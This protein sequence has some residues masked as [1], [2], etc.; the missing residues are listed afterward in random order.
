MVSPR[1]AD[2]QALLQQEGFHHSFQRGG[3]LSKSRRHG[4]KSNG[5]TAVLVHQQHQQ[6]PVSGIEATVIHPVHAQGLGHQFGVNA[7]GLSLNTGHIPNPAQKTVG[8]SR[9]AAAGTGDPGAGFGGEV[10]LQQIRRAS[11]DRL[12]VLLAVELQTL[13][14]PETVPQR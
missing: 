11:H 6:P 1:G 13:N 14:Q 7:V 4:L 10:D 9:G 12:Q 8:D 5:S 3:I 2:E